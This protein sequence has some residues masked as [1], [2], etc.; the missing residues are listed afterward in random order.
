MEKEILTF[1]NFFL[2]KLSEK[3]YNLSE[4]EQQEVDR[5]VDIYEQ[6]FGRSMV[7][8]FLLKK[9]NPKIYYKKDLI[10]KGKPNAGCLFLGMLKYFDNKDQVE[11]TI[12]VYV[13]FDDS[14]TDRGVYNREE[15]EDGNLIWEDIVLYQR[16]ISYERSRI[17]DALVH[18]LFHAK[19]HSKNPKKHYEKGGAYY[20]LDPVETAAYTSNIIKSLDEFLQDYPEEKP[21]IINYLKRFMERGMTSVNE[22]TPWFL[23]DKFEFLKHLYDNRNNPKF[24]KEF[25]RFYKKIYSIYE[26][27]KNNP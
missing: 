3:V 17:E 14:S 8:K 12:P 20:W 2:E 18:E 26:D 1:K 10:K 23:K 24:N 4:K 6:K 25:Q 19:S 9:I 11:R 27:L 15:D 22:D 13:S 21:E 5:I 16:K 7:R